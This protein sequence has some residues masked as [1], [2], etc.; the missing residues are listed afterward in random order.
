MDGVTGREGARRTVFASAPIRVCDNGGWTDTW[1]AGHGNVCNIA[2][3]P[4]VEARVAAGP[5]DAA[6]P[7]VRL[8]LET[9]GERYGFELGAPPGRHP[10]LEAAVEEI[11]LADGVAASVAVS[12]AV[13]A[14][15]STGTSAAVAV[16]VMGA[17]DALSPSRMSLGDLAAA[18]H[19]VEVER[20]GVE[21]GIQD[22][23]CAAYG[24][25]SYIEMAAYPDAVVSAV[26]PPDGV[27]QELEKRLVLVLLGRAH[28][29]SSVHEQVID[30]LAQ[31]GP[32]SGQLHVLRHAAVRAREAL[33]EGDLRAFGAVM[34]E[35][36]AAQ[37]DLHPA[38][39]G[40]H[41]QLV[42][43]TAR[44]HGAWGWK[45]NGAGGEGGSVTLLCGPDA[46]GQRELLDA[47]TRADRLFTIAPTR[48]SRLGLEIRG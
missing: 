35:N 2:M 21:S 22:Q 14:G 3:S 32:A 26:S 38:L 47:V 41:A 33:D 24:G 7:R 28:R 19:R 6:V 31:E 11:G 29:S 18:A 8:E 25:I 13:P 45:V 1:F 4:G 30:R 37:A 17:L 46:G 20:L 43:D 42:I 44:T 15:S 12:S 36:T 9:F 10:L 48:I 40:A 39:V 34:Q 27:W 16:A 23:L 5:A